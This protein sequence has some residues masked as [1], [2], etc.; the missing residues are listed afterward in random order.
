MQNVKNE[1]SRGKVSDNKL[2]FCGILL[3]PHI[4]TLIH[5]LPQ[6]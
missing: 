5:A 2:N 4:K 3:K 1:L 6:G